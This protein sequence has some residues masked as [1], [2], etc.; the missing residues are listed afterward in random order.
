MATTPLWDVI[1]LGENSV[2]DVYRVPELPSA[3]AKLP[4][5]SH[6][7]FLGGQVATTISACAAF[8]LR[9]KYIGAFGS[10]DN[11]RRIREGLAA[12]GIDVSDAVVRDAP[13]RHAIILVHDRTGE[14]VVL[15]ARD[16]AL[17]FGPRDITP[18]MLATAA[19]VHV[20]AVHEEAALAA[21]RLAKQ[22]RTLVTC[23]IDRA[24]P[25]AG[26]LIGTVD[27]AILADGVPQT[28]TGEPDAE[29]AL[30]AL[31]AK[32]TSWLCVTLGD[33]GAMLLEGERLHHAPAF[34]V[35]PV[36]TTGAG[37]VFRAGFLYAML[38]GRSP[39]A[40]LRFANAAAA[41][42][43]TREGAIDSVPSLTDVL[44]LE[45]A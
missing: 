31:R 11:G 1:G 13:N 8:G 35:T 23:D 45:G 30:R 18:G 33:R 38:R 28:M 20:D 9:T 16:A 44:R 2:D 15:W 5:L 24:T 26:E 40:I 37:D 29:R 25:R 39:A 22:A 19:A 12:R 42:S 21:A 36:D 41:L 32:H 10:D 4:I 27:V 43:C 17:A 7:Q 34:D 6:R 14:R 3:A